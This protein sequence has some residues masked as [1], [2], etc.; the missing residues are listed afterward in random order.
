MV[1][2]IIKNGLRLNFKGGAL[3]GKYYEPNN[4]SFLTNEH[5]RVARVLKFLDN[6]VIEDVAPSDLQCINP[7]SDIGIVC[8]GWELTVTCMHLETLI[9]GR[10]LYTKS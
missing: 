2:N 10:G 3:P 9:G 1:Q 6:K 5:F 7:L 4:K 8:G